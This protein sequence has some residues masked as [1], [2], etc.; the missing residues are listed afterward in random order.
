M[1]SMARH[2]L[3]EGFRTR[4]IR[5]I[6]FI[7]AARNHEQRAFFQELNEIKEASQNQI[8]VFWT[9]SETN[10]DLTPGKDF[11]HTGRISRDLLQSILPLDDYDCYL[12]GPRG[13]MQACYDILRSLGVNDARIH[14]ESFGPAALKR[15]A[16]Q[17]SACITDKSAAQQAIVEFSD[18]KVEQ[19]WSAED[20]DLL[21]FT[22]SHGL[23]PEFGCRSGQCGA[24]KVKLN[25]GEVT[26]LVEHPAPVEN[27]EVLLCCSVPKAVEGTVMPRLSIDI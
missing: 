25:S 3:I 26:C 10:E 21:K 13:F 20:G 14:A 12:C 1:I 8:N 18:S 16:D 23:T 7:G 22:E 9:L 17:A 6:T 4:K 19:A 15:D 5:P 24:C 11:H 2:A 27:N